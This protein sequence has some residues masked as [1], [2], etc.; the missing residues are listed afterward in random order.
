VAKNGP[1]KAKGKELHGKGKSERDIAGLCKV[2]RATA[3]RWIDEWEASGFPKGFLQPKLDQA[4]EQAAIQAAEAQGLSQAF[5]FGKVR[6]LLDATKPVLVKPSKAD[7]ERSKA[8]G[9]ESGGAFVQEVPD[10]Q[11]IDAGL[12]HAER[13]VP[14][15]KVADKLDLT[16]GGRSILDEVIDEA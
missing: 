16:S 12:T 5:L 7:Q 15:F 6:Q 9:D 10:F 13:T 11:A 3:K 2:T 8:E 14:G 4:R 1:A